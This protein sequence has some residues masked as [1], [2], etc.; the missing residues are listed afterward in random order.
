MHLRTLEEP[1]KIRVT[2]DICHV[3]KF[4]GRHPLLKIEP[5]GEFKRDIILH[6][7]DYDDYGDQDY[8]IDDENDVMYD[9]DYDCDYECF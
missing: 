9:N 4:I 5:F 7:D 1:L 6:G 2:D 3:S 8:D